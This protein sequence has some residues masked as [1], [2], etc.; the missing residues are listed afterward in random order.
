MSQ[1]TLPTCRDC[2]S[3]SNATTVQQGWI[4]PWISSLGT[5]HQCDTH[6]RHASQTAA[7]NLAGT[8]NQL[9]ELYPNTTDNLLARVPAVLTATANEHEMNDG[10][11]WL[12]FSRAIAGPSEEG[13]SLVANL[14]SYYDDDRDSQTR[15][16][17]KAS[18]R[19]YT[20]L[21]AQNECDLI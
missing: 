11:A 10:R 14:L 21:T 6:A 17:Q 18:T 4:M 9:K 20:S 13:A 19:M 3:Y 5:F 16:A 8:V 7:R 15:W 1:S 12:A 2:D